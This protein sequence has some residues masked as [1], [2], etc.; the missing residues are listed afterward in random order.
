MVSSVRLR[1]NISRG[2][3]LGIR[4]G[5]SHFQTPCSEVQVTTNTSM[6]F[7][8]LSISSKQPGTYE[9]RQI[10]VAHYAWPH[11]NAHCSPAAATFCQDPFQRRERISSPLGI[12]ARATRV[13]T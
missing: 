5:M 8:T 12:A 7:A 10:H 4:A 2:Q 1:L 13:P 3:W 9:C 11:S 6:L